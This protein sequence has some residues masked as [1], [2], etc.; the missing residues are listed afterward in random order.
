MVVVKHEKIRY[1]LDIACVVFHNDATFE[2][3]LDVLDKFRL[4]VSFEF[5]TFRH[6]L[7]ASFL[8]PTTKIKENMQFASCMLGKAT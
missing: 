8:Q 1:A 2:T 4:K 5:L 7:P 6:D 3:I